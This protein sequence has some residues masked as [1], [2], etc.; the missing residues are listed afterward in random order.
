[1]ALAYIYT[2]AGQNDRAEQFVR[3]V[4]SSPELF[5]LYDM[6]VIRAAEHNEA[7]ALRWLETAI[8]RHSLSVVWIRVDPRL[9]NI[10]SNPRF[11]ELV[12]RV[13]PRRPAPD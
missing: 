1:M 5:D 8:D 4:T 10:R 7:E 6:V 9:D 11:R 13:V 2:V 3:K 12:G